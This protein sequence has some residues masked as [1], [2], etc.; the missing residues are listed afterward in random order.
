[1]REHTRDW[2]SPMRRPR[3]CESPGRL[4]R[5][6]IA[7]VGHGPRRGERSNNGRSRPIPILPCAHPTFARASVL[8]RV[9]Q[10]ALITPPSKNEYDQEAFE[11]M[12]AEASMGSGKEVATCPPAH[13]SPLPN[14]SVRVLTERACACCAR[15]LQGRARS[16][17]R[18]TPTRTPRSARSLRSSTRMARRC[19]EQRRRAADG[20]LCSGRA[21]GGG[22]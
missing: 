13:S 11:R 9:L 7:C 6:E 15:R 22:G 12:H 1:M 18:S 4:A 17:R 3:A 10:G 2:S 16:R 20:A 8:V 19:P 5:A 14:Q 21:E